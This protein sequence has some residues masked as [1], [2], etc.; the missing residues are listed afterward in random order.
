[1]FLSRPIGIGAA[2]AALSLV[3]TVPAA[4]AQPATVTIIVWSYGFAPNPIRLKAG[5]PVTLV[6]AN[7]SGSGHDFTASA[8][9]AASSISAGSVPN[10]EVE[11]AGHQT[12]SI[13]LTPRAGVYSAHCSHFMHAMFGMKDQI[14]VN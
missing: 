8:F 12:R 4:A 11:L 10:G 14:I 1:M 7:R 6:F 2:A 13:T 9:F 5:Q 3:A